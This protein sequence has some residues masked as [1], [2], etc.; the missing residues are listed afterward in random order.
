[1]N[2]TSPNIRYEKEIIDKVTKIKTPKGDK[3]VVWFAFKPR[4]KVATPIAP[5]W[6]P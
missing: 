1:M 6:F 3:W 4:F 5:L 2:F